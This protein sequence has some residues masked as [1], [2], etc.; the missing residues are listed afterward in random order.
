MTPGG[1]RMRATLVGGERSRHCAIPAPPKSLSDKSVLEIELKRQSDIKQ[2][3]HQKTDYQ[4]AYAM[5]YQYQYQDKM[6]RLY[7]THLP[8]WLRAKGKTI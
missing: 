6:R 3:H 5:Q 1:N 2:V 4:H 8:W 7:S